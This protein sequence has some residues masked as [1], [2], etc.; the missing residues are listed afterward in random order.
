MPNLFLYPYNHLLLCKENKR[1]LTH[2][3][4]HLKHINQCIKLHLYLQI[5][6]LN[7]YEL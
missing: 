3:K 6:K 4:I 2:H 5:G 1:R 7:Q